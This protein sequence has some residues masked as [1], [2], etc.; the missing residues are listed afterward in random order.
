VRRGRRPYASRW[1]LKH[2]TR[3]R[4]AMCSIAGVQR[5]AANA[6][7]GDKAG[8]AYACCTR[9]GETGCCIYITALRQGAVSCCCACYPQR[10]DGQFW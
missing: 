10:P 5:T 7:K 8:A 6:H 1:D 4:A 2:I 9:R 3:V